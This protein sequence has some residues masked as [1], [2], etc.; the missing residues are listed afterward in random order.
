VHDIEPDDPEYVPAKHAVHATPSKPA[1]QAVADAED[2]AVADDVDVEV[3]LGEEVIVVE[4]EADDTE[5]SV[6]EL[7]TL[8][9]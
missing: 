6:I 1:L 4:I 2:E 7:I 3:T 5:D 9:V 8:A